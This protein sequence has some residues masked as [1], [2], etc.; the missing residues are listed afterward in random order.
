[1][2]ICKCCKH[3]KNKHIYETHIHEYQTGIE[4]VIR[5]KYKDVFVSCLINGCTCDRM[6][7]T[8]TKNQFEE[9]I[10]HLVKQRNK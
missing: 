3:P 9:K 4:Q 8:Y 2:Q 1:M 5:G 7:G 6:V 10:L